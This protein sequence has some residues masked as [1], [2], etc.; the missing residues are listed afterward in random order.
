MFTQMHCFVIVLGPDKSVPEHM[1]RHLAEEEGFPSK[2][3]LI[4][5]SPDGN[6][7]ADWSLFWQYTEDICPYHVLHSKVC[8]YCTAQGFAPC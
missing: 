7:A 1:L 4:S 6:T 3:E 8:P 2:Q 5:G